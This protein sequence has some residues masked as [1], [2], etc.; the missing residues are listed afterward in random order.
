M[1]END[2][3]VWD[4]NKVAISCCSG[5]S[6]NGLVGRAVVTDVAIDSDDVMSICISATSADNENFIN[7]IDKY[8]IIAINGCQSNCVN[9]ILKN[10]GIDVVRH[11]NIDQIL[12]PTGHEPNDS[13]RL[14]EEGEIC[15]GIEKEEL[16]KIID[17]ELDK[18]K[19]LKFIIHLTLIF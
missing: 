10:K 19:S 11:I 7:L 14:D 13:A 8:P 15:V 4:D 6:P 12:K 2:E 5:M 3:I 1:E 17:E 16:E 18:A 9:K